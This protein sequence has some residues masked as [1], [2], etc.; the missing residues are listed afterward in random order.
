MP[1][2]PNFEEFSGVS[3]TTQKEAVDIYDANYGKYRDAVDDDK[4][5]LS[6]LPHA[7]LPKAPDPKPFTIKG[8]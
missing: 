4:D 8:G 7:D 5:Q 3:S 2:K 1:D 6:K